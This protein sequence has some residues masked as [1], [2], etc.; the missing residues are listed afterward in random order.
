MGE[1]YY[2]AMQRLKEER[3]LRGLTQEELGGRIG[4]TQGHYCKVEQAQKRLTYQE[5]GRLAGEVDLNYVY[6]GRRMKQR[7]EEM[8]SS[9]SYEELFDYLNITASLAACAYESQRL[10]KRD[11]LY[12]QLRSIRYLTGEG[13]C[14]EKTVFLAVRQMEQISQKD[15]AEQLG[16]DI[17][18]YRVLE[19]GKRLPD[20]EMIWRLYDIYKVPFS[21]VL[22]DLKGI[23]CEIEFLLE[24]LKRRRTE[25]VYRYFELLGEFYMRESGAAPVSEN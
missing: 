25:A 16:I 21:L 24:G 2:D 8:L 6:A 9:Y 20:S 7:H 10:S 23:V 13:G 19:R 14:R 4:M 1:G 11:E 18:T 12:R 22:R 17:K 5:L 3:M 15:M